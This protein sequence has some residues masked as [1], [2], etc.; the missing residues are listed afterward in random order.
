MRLIF[1]IDI[2]ILFFVPSARLMAQ[3]AGSR[4]M[5]EHLNQVII[6]LEDGS[7]IEDLR[8]ADEKDILPPLK[9]NRCLSPGLNIWLI[10]LPEDESLQKV[11]MKWLRKNPHIRLL[12]YNH[13]ITF[14]KKPNDPLFAKQWDR[15]NTGQQGGRFDADIDATEAWDITTGGVTANGDS[16][17]IAILDDGVDIYH[18][19]LLPN[20]WKN[21]GEVPGNGTDDDQNGYVDDYNGW[22]YYFGNDSIYA[23]QHGT[24]I[25]GII[26]AKGNNGIGVAGIN[27]DIKMLPIA[28][29]VNE[30][31]VV[32]AYSYLLEFRKRYN[33]SGGK[34]GAF[35]VASNASF[36]IDYGRPDSFP[37][38]CAIYD[39]LG[40]AGIL[41]VAAT[42]NSFEDVD[43]VG[44]MPTS[45]PSPYLITVTSTDEN[46]RLSPDAAYGQI[47]I[48]LGAPGEEIEST[49][50]GN[51]Y[52]GG[53]SG[54][55]FAAP[56]VTGAIALIYAS[57]CQKII[58]DA[59]LYPDSMA[60]LVKKF[61]L[62][63][64]DTLSDLNGRTVS[65][66][67]LNLYKS[68]LNAENYSDCQLA[69]VDNPKGISPQFGIIRVFP[70]PASDY[71]RIRYSNLKT[72]NNRFLLTD[73]TGRSIRVWDDGIK[74]PG[75][76]EETLSVKNIPSGMYFLRLSNGVR[77]SHLHKLIIH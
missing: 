18:E 67:R 2:F 73:V 56:Q 21:Q 35:I 32:E 27:W 38:W 68:L 63:G 77:Q 33:K 47:N 5:P 22:D 19:D 53:Y 8:P 66:G 48:D 69:Y 4:E 59:M 74:G 28:V 43:L 14:R 51:Q 29:E 30:A 57:S 15:S 64:T 40:K 26:G 46:D 37:I 10:E 44:D 39:S 70:N 36:G 76:H 12:Q 72:G 52:G 58:E 54:T 34:E 11:R 55:S 50:P 65:N 49:A 16:I 45:C 24:P 61:I 42:A 17:V 62:D 3:S 20:M 6:W 13:R 31:S 75:I 60:L 7:G 41:S 9:V 25:A 1:Y 71:I 23:G